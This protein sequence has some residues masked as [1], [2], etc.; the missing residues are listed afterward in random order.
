MKII[1]IFGRGINEKIYNFFIILE[2]VVLFVGDFDEEIDV[3]DIIVEIK[4]KKLIRISEFYFVY[5]FL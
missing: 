1:L 5:L 3:R 2:V 4:G